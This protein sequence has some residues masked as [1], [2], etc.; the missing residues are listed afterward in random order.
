MSSITETGGGPQKMAPESPSLLYTMFH[1]KNK[2]FDQVRHYV[3]FYNIDQLII[4]VINR[5][6]ETRL[7][8]TVESPDG[9]KG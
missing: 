3:N 2:P 9:I 5:R 1:I 4:L 7:V 6:V 8:S